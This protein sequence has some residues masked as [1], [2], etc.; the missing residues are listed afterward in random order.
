PM[1]MCYLQHLCDGEGRDLQI[2]S[3]G[4]AALVG[5]A[6]DDQACLLMKEKGM[7]ID[8]HRAQQLSATLASQYDLILVMEQGHVHAVTDIAPQ[9]RG[10]VHLLGKWHGNEEIADPYKQSEAHFRAAWSAIERNTTLWK[11]YL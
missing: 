6:A 5:H 2:S 3:A 9:T 4:V 1:A 8:G 7:N 10:R 11:K